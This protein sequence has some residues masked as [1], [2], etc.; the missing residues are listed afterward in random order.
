[1]RRHEMVAKPPVMC[2]HFTQDFWPEQHIKDPFQK[3]TLRR[4]KNCEHKNVH[5]KKDCKSVDECKVHRGGYNGFNQCL[6]ATQS[7]IFLFDKCVK[8]FHKFSNSNRHKISH[9]EKKLFKCKQCG[10][11]FCML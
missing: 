8:A 5:L 2:S 9:T 11:S 4:Y 1:M 3:V 6:P 7:K 10:K